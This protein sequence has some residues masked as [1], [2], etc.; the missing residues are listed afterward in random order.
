MIAGLEFLKSRRFWI[1][2]TAST[3]AVTVGT[4]GVSVMLTL[5]F[6]QLARGSHGVFSMFAGFAF[7][8]LVAGAVGF[9]YRSVYWARPLP[10]GHFL[11]RY[12]GVIVATGSVASLEGMMVYWFLVA[13]ILAGRADG[14]VALVASIMAANFFGISA[15]RIIAEFE[16]TA[17]MD[18][19]YGL[20][21]SA[22]PS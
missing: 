4:A 11:R 15:G 10:D 13:P 9:S 2:L 12:I 19:K 21:E 3:S 22:A 16:Q 6:P 18:A 8:I 7:C 14:S 17:T 1:V 20:E 5:Y